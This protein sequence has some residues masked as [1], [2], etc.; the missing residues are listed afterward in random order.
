MYTRRFS[1]AKIEFTKYSELSDEKILYKGLANF[2]GFVSPP[3]N[4]PQKRKEIIDKTRVQ[5]AQK[6]YDILKTV[7]SF[8]EL[9][10][11]QKM[12]FK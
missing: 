2:R 4:N 6:Q 9:E 12:M 3:P 8:K 5:L 10:L 7:E 11:C 1:E